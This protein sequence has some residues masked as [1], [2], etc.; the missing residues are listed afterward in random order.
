MKRTKVEEAEEISLGDLMLLLVEERTA[1]E[2]LQRRVTKFGNSGH[3]PIP[4]KHVGKEC[5]VIIHPDD[6]TLENENSRKFNQALRKM[7]R[8][9]L[10]K[11]REA[12]KDS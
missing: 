7:E 1:D 5:K 3:I 9:K 4:L 10:K 8:K 12:K 11:L 2:I 6:S